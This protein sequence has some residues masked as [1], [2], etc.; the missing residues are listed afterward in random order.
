MEGC[1]CSNNKGA[2]VA[3]FAQVQ[4]DIFLAHN[5]LSMFPRLNLLLAKDL[6]SIL[7]LCLYIEGAHNDTEGACTDLAADMKVRELRFRSLDGRYLWRP[8]I[9]ISIIY[10]VDIF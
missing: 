5:V 3:L 8:H 6:D 4:D 1:V 2:V 9:A 10:I 7:S